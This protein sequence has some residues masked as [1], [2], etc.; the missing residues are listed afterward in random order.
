[1]ESYAPLMK[2]RG[3]VRGQSNRH[4]R[5]FSMPPGVTGLWQVSGRNELS[6]DTWMELDLQYIDNWTL[7]LDFKILVKTVPAVLG[8]RGAS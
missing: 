6:F 5:R 8:G 7:G 1:M 2:E 4:R 3:P